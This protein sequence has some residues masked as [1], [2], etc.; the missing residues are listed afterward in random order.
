MMERSSL[1]LYMRN[2]VGTLDLSLGTDDYDIFG[3][4]S[5]W[6]DLEDGHRS[7]CPQVWGT[8]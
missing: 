8:H 3:T 6:K 1:V 2:D 5:D 7:A 4:C